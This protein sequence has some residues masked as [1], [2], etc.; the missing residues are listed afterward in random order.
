MFNRYIT[1]HM[2]MSSR[3]QITEEEWWNSLLRCRAAC[4]AARRRRRRRL[5]VADASTGHL[6]HRIM[7]I[8]VGL[9]PALMEEPPQ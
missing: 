2:K 4:R 9:R 5:A 8:E 1:E 3:F 6:H 7:A